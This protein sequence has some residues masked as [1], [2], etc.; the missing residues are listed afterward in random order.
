MA[1]ILSTSNTGSTPAE[2][3]QRG[4]SGMLLPE[5]KYSFFWLEPVINELHC[6][7]T[8]IIQK[9][10]L[11]LLGPYLSLSQRQQ[12][13]ETCADKRRPRKEEEKG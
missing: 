13:P 2:N 12:R 6:S 10:C 5:N 1:E 8:G 4:I 11:E 9:V 7:Y 3:P